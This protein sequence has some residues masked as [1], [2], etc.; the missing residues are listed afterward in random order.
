MIEGPKL[1]YFKI[2]GSNMQNDKNKGTKT[3]IKPNKKG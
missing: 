2:V 1:S 3:I